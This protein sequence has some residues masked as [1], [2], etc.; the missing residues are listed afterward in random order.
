MLRIDRH[1]RAS[2]FLLMQCLADYRECQRLRLAFAK[3]ALGKD[4][5]FDLEALGGMAGAW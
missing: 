2:R 1:R 3:V 4:I 5:V